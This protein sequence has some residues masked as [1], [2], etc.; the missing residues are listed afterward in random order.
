MT[1]EE[2]RKHPAYKYYMETLL[3]NNLYSD[4]LSSFDYEYISYKYISYKYDND[5][6]MLIINN[7]DIIN[8]IEKQLDC[9]LSMDIYKDLYYI[10]NDNIF[11]FYIKE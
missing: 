2:F 4:L 10:K 6:Y 3:Y 8:G 5:E 7:P 11:Y 9:Y 1:T